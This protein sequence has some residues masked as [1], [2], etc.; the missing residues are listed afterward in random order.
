M[1]NRSFSVRL[2]VLILFILQRSLV[3][4]ISSH[5]GLELCRHD[6]HVPLRW[7]FM[8]GVLA[9]VVIQLALG[10]LE[11]LEAVRLVDLGQRVEV[12]WQ[13]RSR[14]PRQ[15]GQFL[16]RP[17]CWNTCFRTDISRYGGIL[18][19]VVFALDRRQG[20]L[21]QNGSTRQAFLN[22]DCKC[23]KAVSI[24]KLDKL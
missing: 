3:V 8:S 20:A 18:V 2:E 15:F 19:M 1:L 21:V 22:R 11:P 14:P 13:S 5:D 17:V 16:G 6:L 9:K 7:R 10:L 4:S 24:L 12:I 23:K